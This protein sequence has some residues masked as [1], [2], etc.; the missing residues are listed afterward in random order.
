MPAQQLFVKNFY[1]KF[2]INLTNGLVT[3]IRKQARSKD[4]VSNNVFITS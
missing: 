4:M 2:H 1:T 3:D